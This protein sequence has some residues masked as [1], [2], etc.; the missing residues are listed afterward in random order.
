M[1][2]RA[3]FSPAETGLSQVKRLVRLLIDFY[4]QSNIFNFNRA[5]GL[6]SDFIPANSRYGG[7]SINMHELHV[8]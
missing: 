4:T 1:N 3:I 7:M 8:E 5:V 2:P 6:V